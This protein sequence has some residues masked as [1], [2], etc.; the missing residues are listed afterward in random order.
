VQGAGC[1]DNVAGLLQGSKL[2][3]GVWGSGL[4][5]YTLWALTVE[6]GFRNKVRV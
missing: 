3:F 4:R 5:V 2:M 1:K 6:V